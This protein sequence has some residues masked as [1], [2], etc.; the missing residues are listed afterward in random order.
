MRRGGPCGVGSRSAPDRG[1]PSITGPGWPWRTTVRARRWRPLERAQ[2]LGFDRA[3]LEVLQAVYQARAGQINA[4]EPVLRRAFDQNLEPRAEV[5]RELARIYLATYRLGQAAEVVERCRELV[6]SDPQ[7]YMWINE[8][9]SRS[10]TTPAVMIRNYRAALER[11][12]NLDKARLGLAE[13]LSKDRRFDEA[14][15]EY[16][17]YPAPQSQGCHGAGGTGAERLPER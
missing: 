10:G 6:P 15:E 9:E 3:P 16:R 7:P 14:E 12:P 2:R 1:R 17:A 8:I 13:Q 11:D 4:A 5:A